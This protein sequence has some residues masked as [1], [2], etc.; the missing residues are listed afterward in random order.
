MREYRVKIRV[1]G[2]TGGPALFALKAKGY[3]VELSYLRRDPGEYEAEYSA[4]KDG[5]WFYADTPEELLGLVAMWEERGDGWSASTGDE[6]A[7]RDALEGAAPVYD[8]HGNLVNGKDG[9][10]SPARQA[11]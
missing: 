10:P 3:T 2:N 5:C 4:H 6:R 1:A 7:W 11:Q 8:H 9:R